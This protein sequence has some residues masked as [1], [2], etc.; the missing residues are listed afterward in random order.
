MLFIPRDAIKWIVCV[1]S[2][3]DAETLQRMFE[4]FINKLLIFKKDHCQEL[5][6]LSEYSGVVA[7]CK[8][9]SSLSTPEEGVGTGKSQHAPQVFIM[10]PSKLP[11][12][13]V[14]LRGFGED[15]IKGF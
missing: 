14:Y 13:K 10:S 6:P 5:V 2:Q 3:A 9:F 8:L 7:L 11:L 12:S 4:K 1:S 15:F